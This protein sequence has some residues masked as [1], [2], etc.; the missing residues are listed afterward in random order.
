MSRRLARPAQ[1]ARLRAADAM[2][3]VGERAT[4]C[5]E[6]AS[7]TY[8]AGSHGRPTFLNLDRPCPNPVFTEVIWRRNRLR[9][10]RPPEDAYADTR[11]CVTGRIESY[12]GTAGI[13]VDR[14]EQI[15]VMEKP[16]G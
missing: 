16:E 2:D 9:L 6:V 1:N 12:R 3:H 13:E 7:A 14:P 10:D 8:A 15:E 4:V 5:G 11:I